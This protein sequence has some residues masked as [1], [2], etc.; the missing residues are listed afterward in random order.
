MDTAPELTILDSSPAVAIRERVAMRDLPAF[1]G[2]AFGELAECAGDQIAGPP[3]ARYHAVTGDQV[4]VEAAFP[5]RSLVE[6][7]GRVHPIVVPGG[8]AVQV[9]HV[10]DY[11]ELHES[12][13]SIER[14]LEAHARQRA[15]APREIY[16]TGPEVP[17]EQRVTLVVQPIQA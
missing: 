3:F 14:W 4:D 15:D 11:G 5:L 16:L 7:S 10:G 17:A 6:T 9:R 2:R 8:P 12:Y 1:F 13:A